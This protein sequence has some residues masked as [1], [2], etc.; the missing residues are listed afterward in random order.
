MAEE[1]NTSPSTPA[2]G[3]TPGPATGPNATTGAMPQVA[4][5]TH[6]EALKKLA[7]LEHSNRNASEEVERHR[8]K[9]TAYEKAEKEREAAAQAA[10]DA[11]LGEVERTKKAYTDLQAKYDT[12]ISKY[13][14]ELI[15]AQVQVAA[16]AKGIIDTELAA[17]AIQKSLEYGDD[18]LP[19][20]I[21][22][23]LDNLIKSKPY[24]APAKTEQGQPNPA[25]TANP[26][27]Q[28]PAIPAFNVS[29]RTSIAPPDQLPKG[30]IVQLNQIPWKK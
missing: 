12:E 11:E 24:L 6:E 1:Q 3:V 23:A 13:R 5:L 30:Q 27:Q 9:L 25:Q 2:T 28:T 22:K 17:M 21:D 20:N 8:K 29:G 10:K 14:Q 7:D 16:Q 4:A 15:S 19:T 18:G 26:S